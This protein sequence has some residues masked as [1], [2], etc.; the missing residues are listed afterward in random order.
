[1]KPKHN[2]KFS[3]SLSVRPDERRPR[4]I[5]LWLHLRVDRDRAP[6]GRHGR[7][8]F[9]VRTVNHAFCGG[10]GA[11]CRRIP[12]AGGQYNW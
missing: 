2:S 4:G 8:G 7:I 6:N 3:Q 9:L 12:L 1:M 11:D 10:F 5:G